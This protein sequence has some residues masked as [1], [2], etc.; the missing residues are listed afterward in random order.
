M[1]SKSSM[2]LVG[3]IMS[4][5]RLERNSWFRAMSNKRLRAARGLEQIIE[6]QTWRRTCTYTC[7]RWFAF[8]HVPDLPEQSQKHPSPENKLPTPCPRHV[9]KRFP[10]SQIQVVFWRAVVVLIMGTC[11][12]HLTIATD[13]D[14]GSHAQFV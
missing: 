11:R 5:Y 13:M 9:P 8:T 7:S 1:G 3:R 2:G 6:K 12:E 4:E 10:T 14:M